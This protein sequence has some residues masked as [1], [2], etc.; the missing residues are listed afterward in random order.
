MSRTNYVYKVIFQ[1]RGKYLALEYLRRQC[2][3]LSL[4]ATALLK[5]TN[6]LRPVQRSRPDGAPNFQ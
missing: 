6:L 1:S 4:D 2:P 5:C 3:Y